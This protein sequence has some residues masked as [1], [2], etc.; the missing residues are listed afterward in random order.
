MQARAA[1]GACALV[2]KRM[3]KKSDPW[4]IYHSLVFFFSKQQ[5]LFDLTIDL[6]ISLKKIALWISRKTANQNE[7]DWVKKKFDSNNLEFFS[8]LKDSAARWS[9]VESQSPLDCNKI[10]ETF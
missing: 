6:Q 10:V 5:Q 4:S 3:M 8:S 7:K 9:Q 1:N 2:I